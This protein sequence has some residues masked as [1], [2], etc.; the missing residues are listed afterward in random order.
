MYLIDTNIFLEVLLGR[1]NKEECID[2]LR[3]IE[4]GEIKAFTTSFTIHS[5]EVIMDHFKKQKEL[6]IFLETIQDFRGLNIYY[7]N[8]EDE[9]SVIEEMKEG[10]DFDDALQS[11]VA[12]KL[13][14]KMVSFDKHFDG[15]KGL[16]RLRPAEAI[17]YSSKRFRL[18]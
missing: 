2:L 16:T 14:L 7:T 17:K 6:K 13:N 8:I 4:S 11:Y 15:V 3:L 5:I 12:K 18:G 1:G 9:I 10:L